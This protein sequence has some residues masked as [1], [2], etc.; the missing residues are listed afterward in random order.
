MTLLIPDINLPK[1]KVLL[2]LTDSV[3]EHPFENAGQA[4]NSGII[5]KIF[6]TSDAYSLDDVVLFDPAKALMVKYS[7]T[8]FY[9]ANEEDLYFTENPYTPS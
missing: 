7:G 1:P 6:E 8:T 2:M 9:L 4:L 5:K 3:L